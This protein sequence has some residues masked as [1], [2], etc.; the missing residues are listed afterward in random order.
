[1]GQES[2]GRPDPQILA[3][4][5]LNKERVLGGNQLTLLAQ[6]NEEQKTMTLDLAKA[7]KSEVMQMK[8]GDYLVMRV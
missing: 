7:M 8:S 6:N 4:V 3:V 5:T 1:M 2:S